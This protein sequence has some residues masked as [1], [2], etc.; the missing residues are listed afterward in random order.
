MIS[1][2][3]GLRLIGVL[4]LLSLLG[5]YAHDSWTRLLQRNQIRDL[6]WQGASL[7]GDGIG[8]AQLALR[9]YGEGGITR[10]ELDG[11]Q[12]SWRQFGIAP[13]FWQQIELQRLALD[14]QP[15]TSS[16]SSTPAEGSPL[17]IAA[18]A[19]QMA[20]LPQR[21]HI[22]EL[23]AQLPCASG[24]CELRGEL[25]LNSQ[26]Q[27]PL[28]VEALLELEHPDREHTDHR[29]NWR[30][31]LSGEPEAL[32]LQLALSLDQQPQL[33][34]HSSLRENA[35]GLH[36]DGEL[37]AAALSQAALLQDWLRPWL[38][39]QTIQL[40]DAPGA[41]QLTARWRL[42]LPP[43]E[44]AAPL[45]L[46]QLR[47]ASGEFAAQANLPEPWPVP[48]VGEVQGSFDVAVRGQAGHW[49]AER[50]QA[51]LQLRQL[52]AE[53]LQQLPAALRM[54]A[55][56]LRIQPHPG[57]AELPTI[58]AERAL[59]LSI[60]LH[61]EGPS[62]LDLQAD[63][64]LANAPPW[65]AQ[66]VQARL[67]ANVPTLAFEPWNAQGLEADIQ[68]SGYL[69]DE[70]ALLTLGPASSLD[71]KQLDH[72]QLQLHRLHAS[73]PGLQLDAGYPGGELQQ[74]TL[75][76]RHEISVQRFEQAQLQA[77]GWRW[78]GQ[79]TADLQTLDLQGQLDADTGLQVPIRVQRNAAGALDLHA[80]L[81]E[82]FLRAGNPLAKT[83]AA[84]PALL[85]VSNGRLSASAQL[86]QSAGG[87]PAISLTLDGKGLDAIYDRT[88][89][90]GLDTHLRLNI[91]GNRLR[92]DLDRLQVAEAN[93]GVP[94]GPL[95]LQGR[96][97]A[98]LA[99]P[100]AGSLQIDR[101]QTALMGGQVS[102]A[103]G[104]WQLDKRP[105][106]FPLRVRGVQ[107]GQVFRHYPTEGLD[108]D[109]TLDGDLPLTLGAEGVQIDNGQLAARAPG[110]RLRFQS[111]SIRALGDSN[112]A[113]KLVTQSL[114]D[115]HYETLSSQVDYDRNGKL[116]L[117]LRL[118][119]R[120][121]A[122]EQGRPINFRIN[123]EEDIPTLLASLQLTDKVNEIITRRVQQ[124]MLERNAA[125]PKE[126]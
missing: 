90:Q 122:I 80:E 121:P 4:A 69:D 60:E 1:R 58:L 59:P 85:D 42:Q 91:T 108:G 124:R 79:L 67:R 53:R 119:G 12:L 126:Q 64:A 46:T 55:L 116:N 11:L 100:D 97:S 17:D 98:S 8:L 111:P 94:L 41:A 25:R 7:S 88:L 112:P 47:N 109:G 3:S 21:L 125:T 20:W 37:N 105:L 115:F 120:N 15:R 45:D 75:A 101:A 68:L 29:L 81:A 52:P 38:L 117:D 57:F 70:H 123:L 10:V 35:D 102:L 5:L 103:A 99:R 28:R 24:R 9:Q 77:Q 86:R 76:G 44:H 51:D 65:A 61:G 89:L 87:D 113:M 63:L 39:K 50:L 92:L 84:W 54:D 62:D 118:Q 49:F 73:V 36:W 6:S 30:A 110:G 96:Y 71:L 2:R 33:D 14:W 43:G 40:P 82:L 106:L 56:H 31:T 66:L 27:A 107:L 22:A 78:Q 26:R 19:E 74:L 32:D 23:N 13:P 83:L 114:E 72:P 104:Q 95:Q 34:L 16:T 93:P 18:L 48:G